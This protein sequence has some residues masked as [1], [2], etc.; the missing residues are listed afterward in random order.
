MSCSSANT[1]CVTLNNKESGICDLCSLLCQSGTLDRKKVKGKI[2]VCLRGENDRLEKSYQASLA[3]AVGMILA[4]DET[5]GND[6]EPDPHFIP[7]AHINF[8]D[9]KHVFAYINSTKYL[10]CIFSF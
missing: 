2:L 1:V 10:S 6:T 9:A 5:T 3:G 7:S 8:I 4:N